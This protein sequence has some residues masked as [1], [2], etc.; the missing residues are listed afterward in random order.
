L[1]HAPH[2]KQ[3]NETQEQGDQRTL[4]WEDLHSQIAAMSTRG[5]NIIVPNAGHYIQFDRPQIV[6]DAVIQAIAISREKHPR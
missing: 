5:I 4:L 1:T 6:I 2:A 3:Q